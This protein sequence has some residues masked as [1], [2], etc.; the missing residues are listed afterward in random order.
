V[1]LSA[2]D[3]KS[4]Y[5]AHSGSEPEETLGSKYARKRPLDELPKLLRVQGPA[6]PIHKGRN[7]IASTPDG[8]FFFHRLSPTSAGEGRLEVKEH[9]SVQQLGR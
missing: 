4:S 7:T 8:W 3:I 6:G 5:H 2:G 9:S 1:A